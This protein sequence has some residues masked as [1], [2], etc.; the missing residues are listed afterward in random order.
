M[1]NDLQQKPAR[2]SLMAEVRI[3]D[4]LQRLG[5]IT[6]PQADQIAAHG[7]AK[8]M[9]F[10]EA[11]VDLGI[12]SR[13]DLYRVLAE[14]FS[15]STPTL[16]GAIQPALFVAS[17]PQS[18]AAEDFR[19][20]RNTLALR[21]FKHPEGSKALA[22]VSP[23]REDG[24]STVAANLAVAFAQV[25]LRTLL[26]DAD[27]RNPSQ[28]GIFQLDDR[29]GLSG[30]LAGRLAGPNFMQ[31]PGLEALTVMPV[32]GVPPN[33]QELLLRPTIDELFLTAFERFEVV[34][35]DTPAA[36]AGSEYQLVAAKASGALVVSRRE[37]TRVQ[38]AQRLVRACSEFGTRIV[39][40]IMVDH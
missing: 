7:R 25:G 11:A 17:Q 8:R 13:E 21:W 27:M 9:R 36:E 20:L 18:D 6:A 14:Q 2:N 24:R 23:N 19:T 40:S 4:T 22:V 5:L 12:L 39:G 38:S 33:P 34:I 37:R 29:Y 30:Y 3:G 15:A 31:I 32:G 28:H 26:I 10:G 1:I 35:L 16:R